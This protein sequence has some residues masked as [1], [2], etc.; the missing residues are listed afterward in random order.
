M[1]QKME[2]PEQDEE[3]LSLSVSARYLLEE[4]RMVLPGIQA[5]FGFQLV[6]VFTDSFARNLS[7][8]EKQ[9]HLV[10]LG[11]VAVAVALVMTPAAIHRRMGAGT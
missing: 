9:L 10:A 1:A 8:P 7:Q 6:S 5:L 2:K 3:R 11:I 4:C